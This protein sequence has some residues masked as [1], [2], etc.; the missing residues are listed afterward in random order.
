MLRKKN[1]KKDR[2]FLSRIVQTIDLFLLPSTLQSSSGV[3]SR[4]G[5]KGRKTGLRSNIICNLQSSLDT[6]MIT[7]CSGQTKKI[8]KLCWILGNLHSE[9]D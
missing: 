3:Q 7:S 5:K 6:W 9:E 2:E 8:E 4:W 1:Y